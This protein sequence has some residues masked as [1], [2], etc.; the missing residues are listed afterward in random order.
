MVLVYH[1]SLNVMDDLVKRFVPRIPWAAADYEDVETPRICVS[2]SVLGC[3]TGIGYDSAFEEGVP[4]I[5][6]EA[7]VPD[8][9]L[10]KPEVLVDCFGVHDAMYTQE[11][12]CMYPITMIGHRY[13]VKSFERDSYILPKVN[14]EVVAWIKQKFGTITAGLSEHELLNDFIRSQGLDEDDLQE[15]FDVK[16][17]RVF[18]K[19]QLEVVYEKV[20]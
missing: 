4:V 11:H 5:V 12:W 6:Y 18:T 17:I 8:S 19:M 14:L 2:P 15:M 20:T 13:K 10:V 1:V 9:W 7:V 16:G 3:F